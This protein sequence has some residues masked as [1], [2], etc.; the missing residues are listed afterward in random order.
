MTP[1]EVSSLDLICYMLK[2][3]RKGSVEEIRVRD[4][5]GDAKH[6]LDIVGYVSYYPSPTK[7][8]NV[9]AHNGLVHCDL[10]F[11]RW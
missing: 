2:Y 8:C 9:M 6:F 11:V 3:I 5:H 1:L 7:F 10:R 4:K